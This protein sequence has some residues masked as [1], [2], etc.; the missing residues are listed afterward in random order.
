MVVVVV[1]VEKRRSTCGAGRR[2]VWVY[3]PST[4][5]VSAGFS[6]AVHGAVG[7][8]A[9]LREGVLDWIAGIAGIAFLG[10][11]R[12]RHVFCFKGISGRIRQG[13]NARG[14]SKI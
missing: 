7:V 12:R 6:V 10:R 5:H 3:R 8:H 9:W 1:L 13:E 14:M 4:A 11:G 2:G